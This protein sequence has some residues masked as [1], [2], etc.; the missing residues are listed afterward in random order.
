MKVSH[1]AR[2]K[3]ALIFH[4]SLL[5][6]QTIQF[7]SNRLL[8]FLLVLSL[9]FLRHLLT[10]SQLPN[11]PAQ[12]LLFTMFVCLVTCLLDF[13]F[14][15]LSLEQSVSREIFLRLQND[16]KNFK[17]ICEHYLKYALCFSFPPNNLNPQ[18]FSTFFS[19]LHPFRD[20]L[21]IHKFKFFYLNVHHISLLYPFTLLFYFRYY[22][23]SKGSIIILAAF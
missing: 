13:L 14:V 2:R 4:C 17:Q 21:N 3:F 10:D 6:L 20:L 15:L 16:I 22:I 5:G 8:L 11:S 19:F 23:Y 18:C 12:R 9:H 1:R 7:L